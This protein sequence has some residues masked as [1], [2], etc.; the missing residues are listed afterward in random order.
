MGGGNG[1][2]SAMALAMAAGRAP[3][4]RC[5]AVWLLGPAQGSGRLAIEALQLR[6]P[7]CPKGL[8]E[9]LETFVMLQIQQSTGLA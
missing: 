6:A 1:R 3:G 5:A 4:E 8:G 7:S 2:L 9:Y